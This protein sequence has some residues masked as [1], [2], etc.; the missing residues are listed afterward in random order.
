MAGDYTTEQYKR[1]VAE[2]TASIEQKLRYLKLVGVAPKDRGDKDTDPDLHAIFVPVRVVQHGS[3]LQRW[4]Q[5]AQGTIIDILERHPGVED[6]SMV[7]L[8]GPGS[9][10]ST[11]LRHLAWSHAAAYRGIYSD[12]LLLSS[13][14]TPL[15]PVSIGLRRLN[16]SRRRHPDDTFLSSVIEVIL[17]RDGIEVDSRMFEQL[18]HEQSMLLLFD[19]LDEIAMLSERKALVAEAEAFARHYPGNHMLVTSRPSGYELTPFSHDAFLHAEVRAFD[20]EQIQQFLERWYTHVLR[21]PSLPY[22]DQHEVESLSWALKENRRLH[23]LAENPL[24]LTVITA[25]HH[26]ERLPDRRVFVYDRYAEI[27]LET[28]AKLKGTQKRWQGMRMGKEDQYACVAHLGFILHQRSQKQEDTQDVAN[29]VPASFMLKEIERFLD[30]QDLL[31][32]EAEQ[33]EEA[34]SFLELMQREAG[35]IVECGTDENSNPLYRFVHRTFQEYFAA[36]YIYHQYLQ[37]EDPAIVSNFL[38]EYLHDPHWHEVI[39][40]LLGKLL[41]K[42][43]TS[44]LNRIL[45]G[46][47]K[48]LRSHYTDLLQQDLFFVCDC[49]IE[50]IPVESDLVEKVISHLSDLVNYSPFPSQRT[51]A[52]QALSSLM[53]T[54]QY[55]NP[56][57]KALVALI[58]ENSSADSYTKS[59]AAQIVD[60]NNLTRPE[61]ERLA[62]NIFFDAAIPPEIPRATSA[63]KAQA[64]QTMLDL[65]PQGGARQFLERYWHPMSSTMSV[66]V[67]DIPN[68]AAIAR[69]ELLPTSIRDEMYQLLSRMVPQFDQLDS[70]QSAAVENLS[71]Q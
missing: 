44:Q 17:R 25:L 18:L 59:L 46:T 70:L 34:R 41:R 71:L 62:A 1:D 21:L 15:V 43:A 69:Q 58:T 42:P 16:E 23:K 57:R 5:D 48:G 35:L 32:D 37:A 9:G 28:W 61:E 33:H 52:L 6:H 36:V 56:A 53:Q 19:G 24:L 65:F 4:E 50:E 51:D 30:Q 66:Q 26:Y 2:Y 49:L 27:L 10:K 67:S 29:D 22:F 39:L 13:S 14:H 31:L 20:D 3:P 40:L 68:A 8:G 47:M 60:Q 11:A 63:D 45:Q 55:A 12:A 64:P 38:K 7:L 54:Q